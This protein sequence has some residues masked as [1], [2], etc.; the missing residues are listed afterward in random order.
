MDSK[1][2]SDKENNHSQKDFD[3]LYKYL[4]NVLN[5]YK[6]LSSTFMGLTLTA[7]IFLI[8]LGF[9]DILELVLIIGGIS[10]KS[11]LL[12]SSILVLSFFLF[13]ISTFLLHSS[14]LKLYKFYL[15]WDSKLTLSERYQKCERIRNVYYYFAKVF[16]YTGVIFLIIAVF[17]I[18]LTFSVGG[19][20]ITILTLT[21][22]VYIIVLIFLY[23]NIKE[24][25]TKKE[26]N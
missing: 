17:F 8:S 10:I 6:T 9:P 4:K 11:I 19:I 21:I 15:Y 23:L 13:L 20:I 3:K 12:S 26:K 7:F 25:C 14:V 16:L 5:I 1:I 22:V 2:N 18:F 24:V